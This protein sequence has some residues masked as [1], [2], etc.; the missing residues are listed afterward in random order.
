MGFK[1]GGE[2]RPQDGET[3]PLTAQGDCVEEDEARVLWQ[4]VQQPPDPEVGLLGHPV[5]DELQVG[6]AVISQGPRAAAIEPLR[7]LGEGVPDGQVWR[8]GEEGWVREAGWRSRIPAEGAGLY[9]MNAVR[10]GAAAP[11]LTDAP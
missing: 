6:G 4:A 7:G 5:V 2:G 8:D 3:P 9:P 10:I 11:P 1:P